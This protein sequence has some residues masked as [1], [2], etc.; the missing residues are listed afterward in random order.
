M[1]WASGLGAGAV[2]THGLG[3]LYHLRGLQY[4]ALLT[5]TLI[6][7]FT[8]LRGPIIMFFI[9]W[10]IFATCF[11]ALGGCETKERE[12]TSVWVFG[13]SLTNY[14]NACVFPGFATFM[15]RFMPLSR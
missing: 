6:R 11:V 12:R 14:D 9:F 13:L 4:T 3:I 7:I 5:E 15:N 2:V 10:F 8:A 1:N